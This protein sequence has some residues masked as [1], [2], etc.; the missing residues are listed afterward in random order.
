MTN[1]HKSIWVYILFTFIILSSP[2][3]SQTGPGGIGNSGTNLLWLRADQITGLTDGQ[4]ISTWTDVSGNGNTL[5]QPISSL[6]PEYQ[7]SIINGLPVVRF[8]KTNGRIRRGSFATFPTTNITAIYVN[9]NSDSGDGVI[10]YASTSSDNDFLLF[11]SDNLTVYRGGSNI[12]SSVSFS[13]NTFHIANANWRSSDGR[14]EVWKDGT[15]SFAATGFRTG[16]PI[17]T[18]GTLAIAGEQDAQD[19]NYADSQAHFGDFA[20]IMIFNT[21]LNSAQHIIVSNYLSSK[22]DLTI[23]NDRFSYDPTHRHDLAGIGRQ[24]ASNVHSAAMSADILR[25]QNASGL[26]AD[27]E[28]LLFGHD[29]TDA[30]TTW[31]TT[32]APNSGI[33]IQRLVREWRLDETGDVGTIDV[34]VN[35]AAMPVL[36]AGHTM[37]ALM[38]DADGDFSSGA[39]IYE[40]VLSSGTEYTVVG[41]DF[42]GGDYVAIAAVRPTIQHTITSSSGLE[43][44]NASIAVE[45]N[46]IPSASRTVQVTTANTA[47]GSATAGS[48]YTALVA[49][50]ATIT[51]GT[52]DTNYAVIVENDINPEGN[53]TFTATLANPSA[54]LNLGTNTVHTYSIVDN[55]IDRKVYFDAATTNGSETVT[56]VNIGL[57]ISEL[58]TDDPTTVDYS[59]TGGTA[60]DGGTDYTLASGTVV[61]LANET[62]GTINIS[63]NNETLFENNETVIITLSNPTNSNLDSTLPLAG[64]GFITHTYTITNDDTAPEIQFN[65]TSSRG[66]ETVTTVDFQIDLSMVSGADASANYTVAE[67][68]AT[69]G[70]VDYTL[71]SGTITVLAGSVS[72]NITATIIN[73]TVEELEETFTIT[74][75]TPS[76]ATLG[77]NTVHTYTII[78]N[79][80]IGF[81]GPGG[82]GQASS[83]IFWVRPEELSVVT[84]GTDISDWN[85]FSGNNNH[86]SQAN[87]ALT[88]RYYNSILNGQPVVRFE[89][90]NN[91]MVRNSFS[92]FAT[93]QISAFYVNRTTDSGE[94]IL[95][96]ASSASDNDFLFFSSNNLQF[97]R[98]S[99]TTTGLSF[100]NNVFNI[101]GATWQSSD[102][103]TAIWQNGTQSFSTNFQAGTFITS[104][105][106]LAV[107]GEQD[108]INTGYTTA[109]THSG[110]FAEIVL[111]N[112][113]LNST[114]S[115]IVQNYLAAKYGLDLATNDIYDKDDVGNGD[116]DF[117]VAGIGRIGASNFHADAK[118]SGI[119][120]INDPQDLG[121][122]EF[123]M[124]GHNNASLKATNT[125]DVPAGV[126]ARFERV[127]RVS[128]VDRSAGAVD[129][130]EIDISFDLSGLGG[131][132]ITDLVLVV[133]SD[134]V[135]DTD[136]TE[137]TGAI[138]DGGNVYRFN[139]VS[140][141]TNNSYFTLA[142]RDTDQTPLP[143]EL[144][145]F[146]VQLIDNSEASL[147]WITASE[148]GNSHF[149][150]ERSADGINYETLAIIL[151]AGDSRIERSYNYT[152]LKPTL[153]RNFY[154]LKQTD[155]SGEF[156]YSEIV[157]A[158]VNSE[159]KSNEY[160]LFPIPISN[161]QILKLA[162]RSIAAQKIVL[163]VVSIDGQIIQ[164]YNQAILTGDG[165]I[166]LDVTSW[167]KGLNLLIIL[168]QNGQ[169]K[170]FRVLVE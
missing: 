96:Y 64:T 132:T 63:V 150:M 151:G 49:S 82:V 93:D 167:P 34:V 22:Y 125:T 79:S 29:N 78:N 39:S 83:N 32:E 57:S 15:L 135:F 28:Y 106:T 133:D 95:S 71:A 140:A 144:T 99:S 73:D 92:D 145:S 159:L 142:T 152:D 118:G 4:D 100:N 10:S 107:G 166:E 45:L 76:D 102:G 147:N 160:R 98:G 130:G 6:T 26:N 9:R 20:E 168:D 116:H 53:E 58:D 131:V 148:T 86:L 16:V 3:H 91:R 115:I 120:R 153:G 61:F 128:E 7:S 56:S 141:I 43:D 103:A 94:G 17:T 87:T 122:E 33:N 117:E 149:T 105:G 42:N 44:V 84:D 65:A 12:N 55:D 37:Y 97:F 121:D 80:L 113:G 67:V 156:E 143:I 163:K 11:S 81:T 66:L 88:P 110:D 19:D 90:A 47:M 138:S 74:I 13:D 104:G 25:I 31:T 129:V 62:V 27:P 48:D 2:L 170:V 109:Q 112:L 14:V 157:S 70:G 126:S 139:G 155:F 123:L 23:A 154:R 50:V 75:S 21:F 59:V 111:Y 30:S 68:T 146:T 46:F 72:A 169:H 158:F 40:M 127:W 36:P 108:G 85:D 38:V 52:T 134:G 60:T 114:Q 54:G 1:S 136:A 164:E 119:V 137:V 161:D 8:N 41:V 162:Y 101:V 5:S 165:Q 35:T 18:N 124:W 24:D 51:A 77:T 89:Q 69:N